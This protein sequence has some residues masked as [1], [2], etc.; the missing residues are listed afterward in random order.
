MA[1]GTTLAILAVGFGVFQQ[2]AVAGPFCD[3]MQS[4]AQKICSRGNVGLCLAANIN[5]NSACQNEAAQQQDTS[6]SPSH[7][8]AEQP[9]SSVAPLGQADSS[10][11]SGTRPGRGGQNCI[12][13][14][15]NPGGGTHSKVLAQNICSYNVWLSW[16]FIRGGIPSMECPNYG[17]TD[18][19]RILAHGSKPLVTAN[20]APGADIAVIACE[21][22]IIR[23]DPGYALESNGGP[24]NIRYLG[25]DKFTYDC[26]MSPPGY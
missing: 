7:T 21:T 14:V 13:F 4:M 20:A 19:L 26:M 16:C 1:K 23:S 24:E 8:P 17:G 3:N 18:P 5:A 6:P 2:T 15:P 22:G 9:S 12:K 10:D 11:D 25:G